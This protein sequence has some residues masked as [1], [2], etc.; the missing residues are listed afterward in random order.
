MRGR[1]Q[2]P[3]FDY[4]IV[5]AGS[6]G[7]VLANRLSA[8]S[9]TSVLLIE[10]G[11]RDTH[12]YIRMPAGIAKMATM[13]RFNWSYY[14]EPQKEL[15]NRRLYWPRGKVIG[16]SSSINA[17]CYIR[18]Q[19]RD[20]DDWAEDGLSDWSYENV[21]PA[22]R[23]SENFGAGA[24][25]FHG[26]DGELHVQSLRYRNGLTDAF[27]H[28]AKEA[29]EPVNNDFNGATQHGVGPYHVTQRNGSRCSAAVAFLHPVAS[30][31][32]LT[33]WRDTNVH[34]VLF[35]GQRAY[36]V[37][38]E[39]DGEPIKANGGQIIVSAG[40]INSPQLLMLSGVGPADHLRRMGIKVVADRPGV[41]ENLQDHLDICTLYRARTNATYDFNAVEELAA[42]MRYLLTGSGPGSSNAAEAG[43]FVCSDLAHNDRPDLQLHFVPAQ[44]DDHGRN[45]L[46]GHGFTLHAC[47]L[48]PQSRG[49]L[50]LKSA[51]PTE[52]PALLPNY[53][54]A[55]DDLRLMVEALKVSRRLL[56]Q[57][58][59]DAWRGDAVFAETESKDDNVLTDF[60][61]RKAE[62][63]YH[64]VGTC[65]MGADADAVVSPTLRVN[66]VDGLSVV[67]ASV[68]PNLISGNTN[69]PTIM[70]AERAAEFLLRAK[71]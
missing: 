30:R 55:P 19:A 53:L 52:H 67:D 10:A 24:N 39:Q 7:C 68:M 35:D 58:A 37:A 42:G 2:P 50:R 15:N 31:S 29:G 65:R 32:N 11:G 54:G 26:A 64:P 69:A 12:P 33:V 21:L 23:Q 48:R 51:D 13:E 63:I 3:S 9:A 28:A 45:R 62:T 60:I 18:G 1:R 44:L 36:G 47:V 61:R 56:H 66:G 34:Q 43:G 4:I 49:R 57:P 16:G 5:G 38:G 17:M 40:A 8:N 70:I 27:L 25:A 22:F 14:T 6:A 59:F 46:P 20:Y 41:G 71:L